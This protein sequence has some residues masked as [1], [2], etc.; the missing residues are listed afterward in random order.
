MAIAV[1]V[2]VLVQALAAFLLFQLIRQQGRILLRL[3]RVEARLPKPKSKPRGIPVGREAPDFE[4]PALAGGTVKLSDFRG[5]PVLLVYWGADCGY[6]DLLAPDLV[7]RTEELDAAAVQ[8]VLAAHGSAESNRKLHAEHGMSWPTGL[9]EQVD[10]DAPARKDLDSVTFNGCGTPS[11]CL[12]DRHGMVIRPV[13]TGMDGVLDLADEAIALGS[14]APKAPGR[15]ASL[16]TSRIERDG[17]PPGTPAPGFELDDIRETGRGA[18]ISLNQF[19]GRRL[20]LVFTDPN[21]G[22]CDRLAPQL[23]DFYGKHGSGSWGIV[24]VGRGDPEANRRKAAENDYPF[25][26]VLQD[27]WKLSKEYGIFSTPVAFLIGPHGILEEEVAIG[28]DAIMALARNGL[29]TKE[30]QWAR[31]SIASPAS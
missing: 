23:V 20:L 15:K 6:C 22:P 31:T 11:A 18:T 7:A 17:L 5:S 2:L 29:A 21:C 27:R 28:T 30:K 12:I 16:A 25:P 19:Q 26:Y 1:W 24:M 8:V 14:G 13:Q 3:D 9:I 10:M 4:L